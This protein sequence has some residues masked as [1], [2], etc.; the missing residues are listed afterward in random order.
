MELCGNGFGTG[1]EKV[2]LVQ[3]FVGGYASPS[4]ISVKV[5]K[6]L[7][8]QKDQHNQLRNNPRFHPPE[9][10]LTLYPSCVNIL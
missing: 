3:T 4:V 8:I 1:I 9:I 10:I 5:Q 6:F 2:D 7:A